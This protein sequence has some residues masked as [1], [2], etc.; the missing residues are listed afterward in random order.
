MQ[1]RSCC[2]TV[3][4]YKLHGESHHSS[5]LISQYYYYYFYYYYYYYN[6]DSDRN[7]DIA[8]LVSMVNCLQKGEA[9]LSSYQNKTVDVIE[10]R[11]SI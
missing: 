6:Y 7:E 3:L 10:E 4:L 8:K 9:E 5:S 1:I 2:T 11:G